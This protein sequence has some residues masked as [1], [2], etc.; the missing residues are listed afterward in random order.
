MQLQQRTGLNAAELARRTGLSESMISRVLHGK[1]DPAFGKIAAAAE[2]LGYRLTLTPLEQFTL[3]LCDRRMNELVDAIQMNA[4]QPD[5][6]TPVSADMR[7]LME[8]AEG[9][10]PRSPLHSVLDRMP[11]ERWKA[12]MGGLYQYQD[13]PNDGITAEELKLPRQWTP[14]RR[15]YASATAPD[16][17]FLDYN[18]Y[19]PQGELQWK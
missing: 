2:R 14:L 16:P 9:T 13:W 1:N 5:A 10:T 11:D 4:D 6:W 18:V 8:C 7:Q 19:L 17:V 3:S 12:F 15:I